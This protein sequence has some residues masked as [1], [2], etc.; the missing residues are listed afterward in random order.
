MCFVIDDTISQL[1]MLQVKFLINWASAGWNNDAVTAL[2]GWEELRLV[3][4]HG[5]KVRARGLSAGREQSK[6]L[7]N[8]VWKGVYS[9]GS[10]GEWKYICHPEG[11]LP[12]GDPGCG[13]ITSEKKVW[14]K[15]EVAVRGQCGQGGQELGAWGSDTLAVLFVVVVFIFCCLILQS[16]IGFHT[17]LWNNNVNQQQLYMHPFPPKPLPQPHPSRPQRASDWAPQLHSNLSPAIHPTHDSVYTSMLPSPF[18][19]LS[20]K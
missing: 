18:V 17:R 15:L 10:H 11:R 3:K 12:A 19:P 8:H 5:K 14:R 13:T 2:R 9:Q 16:W 4:R 6:A 20:E 7:R 1:I